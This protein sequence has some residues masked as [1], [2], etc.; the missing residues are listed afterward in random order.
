MPL[1][2]ERPPM[3]LE[4]QHPSAVQRCSSRAW[5]LLR[6]PVASTSPVAVVSTQLPPRWCHDL[7]TPDRSSAAPCAKIEGGHVALNL[8]ALVTVTDRDLHLYAVCVQPLV[9]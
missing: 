1:D 5:R 8:S 7:T 6:C 9:W 2:A 3:P 4:R